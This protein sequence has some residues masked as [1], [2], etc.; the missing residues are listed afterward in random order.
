MKVVHCP[1]DTSLNFTQATKLIREL[2][3]GTLVIPE[4]YTRNP[5][6]STQRNDL[7]IDVV[8]ILFGF[9]RE[10]TTRVETIVTWS[11]SEFTAGKTNADHEEGRS[12][13][14]SS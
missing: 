2:K 5:Q 7:L 9:L 10:I 13:K 6:T 11:E 3:P 12:P 8:R 1:I 4:C 14:T